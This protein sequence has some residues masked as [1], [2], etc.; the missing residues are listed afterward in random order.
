MR[1]KRIDKNNTTGKTIRFRQGF[2]TLIL[3]FTIGVT[4]H[5]QEAIPATG[6]NALGSDGSISYTVGQ[7]VYTNNTGTNGSS[8]Q[9]VQ[10]PFEISTITGLEEARDITLQCIVY[11]NP[12]TDYLKLKVENYKT[13][14][15]TYQ[16]YNTEGKLLETQKINGAETSIA[17][18]NLVPSVYFLKVI[19]NHKEIK[20]FKVIKK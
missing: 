3:A 8:S 20:T 19:D 12:A 4:G 17:M 16:L 10:Q 7:I 18:G 5:A 2:A 6:G 15:L 14:N 11:P 13:A 1:Y 9:G